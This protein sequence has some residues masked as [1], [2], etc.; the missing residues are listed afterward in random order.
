MIR[1]IVTGGRDYGELTAGKA[2]AQWVAEVRHVRRVLDEVAEALKV[3][4]LC[5][6]TVVQGGAA[7]AD[8]RA[9]EWAEHWR[10]DVETFAADWG[11]HGRAAGPKRNAA[12]VDA[13]ADLV[14]AFPGGRGTASCV[15]L[16]QAA[17]LKVRDERGWKPGGGA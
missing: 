17:K 14:V 5:P 7:G 3:D 16:A 9:R 15:A 6:L 11:A 8:R 12:M 10:H 2:R 13:G 4:A 1:V